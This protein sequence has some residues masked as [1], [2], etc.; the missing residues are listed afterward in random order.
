MVAHTC[1]EY[2]LKSLQGLLLLLKHSITIFIVN[3]YSF[4][5]AARAVLGAPK[6]QAGAHGH[7]LAILL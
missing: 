4:K 2:S 5:L 7:V 1:M 6:N 3:S